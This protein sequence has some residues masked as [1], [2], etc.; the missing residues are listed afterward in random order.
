MSAPRLRRE[1]EAPRPKLERI[2]VL[3]TLA[4]VVLVLT[5]CGGLFA[6]RAQA[7]SDAYYQQRAKPR[8]HVTSAAAAKSRDPRSAVVTICRIEASEHGSTRLACSLR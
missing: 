5:L 7:S 1:V 6:I 3:W 4:N 2:L 8:L